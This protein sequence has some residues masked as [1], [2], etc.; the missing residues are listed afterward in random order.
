MEAHAHASVASPATASVYGMRPGLA[1]HAATSIRRSMTAMH[2]FTDPFKDIQVEQPLP[3]CI[4]SWFVG[5]SLSAV[6]FAWAT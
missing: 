6:E 4:C 3:A 2:S 1:P 5:G